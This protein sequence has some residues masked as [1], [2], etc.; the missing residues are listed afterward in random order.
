DLEKF[1]WMWPG[2]YLITEWGIDGPWEGTPKTAWGAWIEPP[3]TNKADQYLW[4][5]EQQMPLDD[6][7]FLGSL[8]FYWGQKQETTHTWFS[9]FDEHGS[10]TEVVAAAERAW[11]GGGTLAPFPKIR[12]MLL[13]GRGAADNIV[14]NANEE[15]GAIIR[16]LPNQSSGFQRVE[17]EI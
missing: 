11:T 17:W 6:S 5:Y 2:P 3:S 14:L 9:L 16:Q 15:V 13:D 8:I 1:E 12:D 4:R 10:K 7:G